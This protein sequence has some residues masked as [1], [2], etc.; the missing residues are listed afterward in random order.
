MAEV[1]TL[2]SEILKT[3]AIGLVAIAA[4]ILGA[5]AVEWLLGWTSPVN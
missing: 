3:L 1:T 2:T 5:L 4:M